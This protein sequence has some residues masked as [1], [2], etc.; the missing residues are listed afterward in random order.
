MSHANNFWAQAAMGYLIHEEETMLK[1][2]VQTCE[3]IRTLESRSFSLGRSLSRSTILP[4]K[5]HCN[6]HMDT[7]KTNVK[8][9][10]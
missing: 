2:I 3:N 5:E 10:T 1:D 7:R 6:Q 9:G 4:A 8:K